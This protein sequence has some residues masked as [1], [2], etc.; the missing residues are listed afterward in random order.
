MLNGSLK[1]QYR[2]T[3]ITA[4]LN[5]PEADAMAD[6][7][8]DALTTEL[9]AEGSRFRAAL[10][11]EQEETDADPDAGTERHTDPQER[12]IARLLAKT[13]VADYFD[14]IA[15]GRMVEGAAAEL[16]SATLG[17]TAPGNMMPLD[18]FLPTP[19]EMQYRID[20]ATTYGTPVQD[21]ASGIAARLFP[22]GA[23]DYMGVQRPT[24]QYGTVSYVQLVSAA[25]ADARLPG[26]A[27]DAVASTFTVQSLNPSRVTARVNYDSI[28]DARLQG[29]SD[30][31]VS[32]LRGQ[33]SQKLDLVGLVG[34]A[35]VTDTSPALVGIISALP[36]PTNPTAA[37]TWVDVLNGY[38]DAV[39]GL[40]STDD[41]N[42][43]M[44]VNLES[45]RFI[46]GLQVDTSGSL[47]R[48]RL[49]AGRFRASANMPAGVSDI[50]TCLT[51]AAGEGRGFVQPVWRGVALIRDP[52]TESSEDRVSV[53][54][55][56]YT[57]QGLITTT[58]YK[59]LEYRTA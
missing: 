54:A 23:L 40:A 4:A 3:E 21:N 48:D 12:E 14:P 24:V 38:D 19:A 58:R 6:A 15:G 52:Y 36:D 30:A 2:M 17:D 22:M 11:V 34:Q 26:V 16:R 1:H 59:R 20:A 31:L 51:Y 8:R 41:S 27:L 42:I 56:V 43:R 55:R 25:V 44:L 9:L 18:V 32:D 46:R 49:P 50:H 37:S 35:A 28:M 33:I 53:S 10:A 29:A 13:D 7:D 47:L 39:D 5:G 57:A 45:W